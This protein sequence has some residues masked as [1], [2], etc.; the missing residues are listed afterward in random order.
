MRSCSSSVL[1]KQATKEIALAHPGAD[2]ADQGQT[3][4][5]TGRFQPKGPV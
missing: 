1:V 2:L 3:G 5:W 4:G